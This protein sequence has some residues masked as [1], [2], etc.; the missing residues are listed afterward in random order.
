MCSSDLMVLMAVDM[1]VRAIR[2]Q[3]VS[4]VDLVVQVARFPNG[5]RRVTHISEITT[6]DP[7]NGEI[8]IED[9]FVLPHH[10]DPRLRHTGYLPTFT[11]DLIAKGHLNVDA[12][13]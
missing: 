3:I 4:A 13:L 7:T 9:I 2:E 8:L 5:Q 11:Q 12:F 10:E 1:P 6:L